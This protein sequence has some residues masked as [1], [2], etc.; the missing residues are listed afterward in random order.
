MDK[1]RVEV[2][3]DRYM[4]IFLHGKKSISTQMSEHLMEDLSLEQFSLV[5]MLYERGEV[6]S[7]ELAEQL[8]VHKSAIT[9]KVEKLVKKGLVERERDTE[10]RRSVYLRLSEKGIKLY[11]ELSGKINQFVE[12]VV[13]DI[14]ESEMEIFLNVYEKLADYIESYEGEKE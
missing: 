5:R 14:P 2:I 3:L 1:K 8:F 12:A 9:V 10:D 7:S 11:E 4:D 6:R 13:R